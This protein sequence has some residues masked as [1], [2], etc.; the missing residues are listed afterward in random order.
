MRVTCPKCR[1]KGSIVNTPPAAKTRIICAQCATTFEVVSPDA[2]A[3]TALPPSTQDLP[4]A[5]LNSP[6]QTENL[7]NNKP[8]DDN[9]LAI[10]QEP[11]AS[12][13]AREETPVLEIEPALAAEGAAATEA[14]VSLPSEAA[15]SLP[16]EKAATALAFTTERPEEVLKDFS[17]AT[18]R[19]AKPVE[20]AAAFVQLPADS[21]SNVDKYRLGV[22]LLQV[23][24]VW[25]LLSGFVFVSFI[26]FCSWFIKSDG[27]ASA[28]AARA[29][30]INYAGNQS[31]AEEAALQ[32]SHG[33]ANVS[34]A[35]EKPAPVSSK[36]V[37]SKTATDAA[38]VAPAAEPE[39]APAPSNEPQPKNAGN[40]TIQVG[41][42][43][44]SAQ[45]AERVASLKAAGFDA[46]VAE[47]EIPKRGTWY[48]VQTGRFESRDEAARYSVQMRAKGAAESVMITEV[49]S[50]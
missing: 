15:V 33:D 35:G 30:S 22:Q 4:P 9:L 32:T 28:V 29:S 26:I 14:V 40:F 47:V 7:M 44:N 6:N 24:P 13:E 42:Y 12:Y 19:P 43:N 20:K 49:Q 39:S 8:D 36:P 5:P 27:Q 3:E 41:S 2:K 31:V 23:R 37:E 18:S 48:R 11:C 38:K 46:R 17:A 16:K 45:A 25:L 50:K 34:V 10:S 21:L 1:L